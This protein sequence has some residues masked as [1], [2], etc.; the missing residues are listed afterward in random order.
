MARMMILL[1]VLIALSSIALSSLTAIVPSK[2]KIYGSSLL[3]ALTLA[4]GTYLV[5]AMHAPMLRTCLTGLA[6][7]AVALSGVI[8][9]YRRLATQRE[10][11]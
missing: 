3:V 1:H 11:L 8:V 7:L 9:G 10:T 6:Y 4:T 2:R 5:I